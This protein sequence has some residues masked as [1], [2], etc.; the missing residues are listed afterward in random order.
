MIFNE[1]GE[2][3][4]TGA[5]DATVNK[6][7]HLIRLNFFQQ[8]HVVRHHDDS[9][10]GVLIA[11][12]AHTAGHDAQGVNV[13]AGVC[14][15][16][17]GHDG[18]Q[19]CHLQH[20]IALT[21]ATTKAVVQ[22]TLR[23][24][25]VH[26]EAVHPFHEVEADF[27]HGEFVE[28]APR[29]NRLPQE[30]D[31]G[32]ATNGFGVLKGEK[33]AGA[34]PLVGRPQ[35]NVLAVEEDLT[36]RDGVARVSHDDTRERG[37]TGAVRA[38]E[39]VDFT[40]VHDEVNAPQN[41]AVFSVDV[42]ITEFEKRSGHPSRLPATPSGRTR[43]LVWTDTLMLEH[44]QLNSG[45]STLDIRIALPTGR[46]STTHALVFV[47]GLPRAQGL[48]RQAAAL[49]PQLAEHVANESGWTVATG[50][51]SGVGASTGTFSPTRWLAD[52]GVLIDF[53][54]AEDRGIS[55]AGFGIGGSLALR[56]AA[57]HD[58]IRGVA[59]FAAPAHVERW[60]GPP[61][62]FHDLVKLAGVVSDT[63]D[64][65]DPATLSNELLALDPLG[66]IAMIP[67]RRLLIGHGTDDLEVPSSE[68]RELVAAAD[69]RAEL[70][71]IQSAGHQLRADPR[72]VATLLGWLD[73]HR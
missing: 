31:H 9:H 68:A 58:D 54:A 57:N 33:D 64:L 11:D 36:L 49:L 61:Q 44:H 35:G 32:D 69:G 52:L 16:E 62:A 60:A 7:V 17:Q 26:P 47:H 22:V 10:G 15:V 53:L 66:A 25:G 51:L 23:E 27:E 65:L 5:L 38:H 37:L 20:L 59:T 41:D 45:E 40:L 28:A 21:L 34:S 4:V 48:G 42:Q 72:M 2:T 19:E 12:R 8:L 71:M 24:G 13:E 63:N 50:T 55:L 67:P 70:R 3:G 29:G 46:L 6:D 1:L 18:R 56:Y 14:F 73:R 43:P 30:L 39:C